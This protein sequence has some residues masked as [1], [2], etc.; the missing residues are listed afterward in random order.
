[1]ATTVTDTVLLTLRLLGEYEV[2]R[3]GGFL[4]YPPSN[5]ELSLLARSEPA[6]NI[7]YG[8]V[9]TDEGGAIR[10][11]LAVFD[12]GEGEVVLTEEARA[13]SLL[14]VFQ[15]ADNL[16][17]T[18]V[19]GF[20]GRRIAFGT[21]RLSPQGA[22]ERPYEVYLDGN[23]LGHSLATAESILTGEH[24][25]R[26]LAETELGREEVF[27]ERIEVEEARTTA[28]TFTIPDYSE[29]ELAAAAATAAMEQ[30]I[31]AVLEEQ[32][33][34]ESAWEAFDSGTRA[35]PPGLEA[36][37]FSL[38]VLNR[39][40][41]YADPGRMAEVAA[42]PPVYMGRE[43]LLRGRRLL[44]E[45]ELAE[46]ADTFRSLARMGARA[47]LGEVEPL[48]PI[49]EYYPETR[50]VA[51]RW[52]EH[53]LHERRGF[54]S[55]LG[56]GVAA[57]SVFL[58]MDYSEPSD[59]GDAA[60]YN[61]GQV[62]PLLAAAGVTGLW[63]GWDQ[64]A[65]GDRRS[66]M[67]Y[68][69]GAG[70]RDG[71]FLDSAEPGK[72]DI[73]V[74][75]GF[76][77]GE[78]SR[79]LAEQVDPAVDLD[80]ATYT[81]RRIRPDLRL[82]LHY[83]ATRRSSF[84]LEY[85]LAVG[86]HE[87]WSE[88]ANEF[89]ETDPTR[90]IREPFNLSLLW[91]HTRTG[92]WFTRLGLGYTRFVDD[93]T[94]YEDIASES[95]P[96]QVDGYYNTLL[97]SGGVIHA[98]N[99]TLGLGRFFGREATSPYQA[100]LYYR[101][102]A[103]YPPTDYFAAPSVQHA[104]GISVAKRIR[105]TTID[106][107]RWPGVAEMEAGE[108]YTD[109]PPDAQDT[110]RQAAETDQIAEAGETTAHGTGQAPEARETR[111][112]ETGQAAERENQKE[113]P[114][115]D[116]FEEA[117]ARAEARYGARKLEF[118]AD[119]GGILFHGP[120][121]GAAYDLGGGWSVGGYLRWTLYA[122]SYL[123]LEP[124]PERVS[125]GISARRYASGTP[126]EAGWFYGA[127]LEYRNNN[128]TYEVEPVEGN[129]ESSGHIVSLF[130]EGGYRFTRAGGRFIDLGGFV[131]GSLGNYQYVEPDLTVEHQIGLWAGLIVSVGAAW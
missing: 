21:L 36:V 91:D 86:E 20:S 34:L 108:G 85:Q 70:R 119:L 61:G 74:G 49:A 66:L 16:T 41:S 104:L 113:N 87:L 44:S 53:E 64:D 26:I 28:V 57:T 3:Y 7:V 93:T 105:L 67:R 83:Q 42:E 29:E 79:F 39:L 58:A 47:P 56:I 109:A 62:V 81:F 98:P 8:A 60:F 13:E 71:E 46:G 15:V 97:D 48:T 22:N 92:K 40:D 100:L 59:L 10:L 6:E 4:D 99:V 131:G 33:T 127:S 107:A 129:T 126:G 82:G 121:F 12:R 17:A 94:Y 110:A 30:D 43:L 72:I 35:E 124:I 84:G 14:D 78:N 102:H 122:L 11:L 2:R 111:A 125:P 65:W 63:L 45:G 75:I 23:L 116:L 130:G 120:R 88:E 106:W 90:V 18:V 54:A 77:Q 24:E 38:T 9:E 112:P 73:A 69:R 76:E 95:D 114:Y 103:L 52:S 89:A 25:L 50:Y 123:D 96:E 68:G 32:R 128:Y 37:D 51:N 117:E 1:M 31:E 101:M 27:R 5:G 115:A 118:F 80:S 19:S 55:A